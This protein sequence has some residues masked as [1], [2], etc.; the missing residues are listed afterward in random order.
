MSRCCWN[1]RF[2]KNRKMAALRFIQHIGRV[3]V[4]G[5]MQTHQIAGTTS[6]ANVGTVQGVDRCIQSKCKFREGSIAFRTQQNTRIPLTVKRLCFG[7]Q[8]FI[9]HINAL[10]E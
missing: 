8:S 2:D 3:R 7:V 6:K 1:G 4:T 10:C 9:E 5:S